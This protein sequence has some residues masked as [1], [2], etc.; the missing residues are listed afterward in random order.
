V[1][2]L[3]LGLVVTDGTDYGDGWTRGF[4]SPSCNRLKETFPRLE[5]LSFFKKSRPG[6][7]GDLVFARFVEDEHAWKL[8][9]APVSPAEVK[10]V[11][12]D[13]GGWSWISKGSLMR[14]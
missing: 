4:L 6:N 10:H 13:W 3:A 5:C 2:H 14:G 7:D 9:H 1:T 11:A 12:D 8:T